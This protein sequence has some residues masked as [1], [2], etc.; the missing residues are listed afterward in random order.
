MRVRTGMPDTSH[1][2]FEDAVTITGIRDEVE[3]LKSLQ[4]PK[5]VCHPRRFSVS[6]SAV[7]LHAVRS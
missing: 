3:V 6:T 7:G 4:R 5:K 1:K 2:L